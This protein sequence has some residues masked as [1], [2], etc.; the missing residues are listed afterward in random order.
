MIISRLVGAHR[1][2]PDQPGASRFCRE[3]RRIA[4]QGATRET[5]ARVPTMDGRGRNSSACLRFLPGRQHAAVS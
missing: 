4:P 2:Q 5:K 3:T 1:S